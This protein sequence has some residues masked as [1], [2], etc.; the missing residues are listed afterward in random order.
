MYA[1]IPHIFSPHSKNP[2][3]SAKTPSGLTPTDSLE[4][5]NA[6]NL[7]SLPSQDTKLKT[8][9]LF[10]STRMRDRP[11]EKKK[12]KKKTCPKAEIAAMQP[13]KKFGGRS[14]S[15]KSTRNSSIHTCGN[16]T[17]VSS[18]R[19]C[20]GFTARLA[21][22]SPVF[23]RSFFFLLPICSKCGKARGGPHSQ[24]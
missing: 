2:K 17:T 23:L 21:R 20:N 6:A 7:H 12:K 1:K 3:N 15:T 24:E 4:E 13:V 11:N 8:K 5:R 14:P 10:Q 18:D 9:H 19:P 22:M 16:P